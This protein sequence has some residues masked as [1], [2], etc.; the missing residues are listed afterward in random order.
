MLTLFTPAPELCDGRD[1]DPHVA[2]HNRNG[3]DTQYQVNKEHFTKQAATV[4]ECLKNGE[5]VTGK[6][7][8][9]RFQ[10]QDVRPRI[11]AIKKALIG[12]DYELQETKIPNGK[13]AKQWTLIQKS[14]K[15]A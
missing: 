13:G 3:N 14:K 4:W 10:I 8:F 5:S 1:F 2:E 11:A 9:E 6:D 12:T 15:V 7:M